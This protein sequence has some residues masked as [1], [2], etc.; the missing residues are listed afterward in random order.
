MIHRKLL[1]AVALAVAAFGA[2]AKSEPLKPYTGTLP[3]ALQY[4]KTAGGLEV[5]KKFPAA[6]GLDG[7][8][9]QDK[10]SGKQLVVYSSK[11]GEVLV[12]G[13]MLDKA[14]K[15]LS[16]TY[17]EEHI[18]APDYTEVM[19]EFM[20]DG[21]SVLV[22][23]P[24]AKAEIMVIFDANCGFCKAMHKL[25]HPAVEAGELRVRYVPV[26]IL[27]ADSDI[28]GAGLLAAKEADDAVTAAVEG[29]AAVSSDKALLDKVKK[30]TALMK[31]HGFGGTP[32]LLYQGK[33]PGKGGKA[34]DTVF[35]SNG[36]PAMSELFARLGISGQVDKLKADPA[37][38]RFLR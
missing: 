26:A 24:K 37:L 14:G 23:S 29:K 36:V 5:F 16:Q 32:V 3:A 30:N 18:P 33:E 12:A 19:A 28:K 10:A 21:A 15:N 31:K 7:W 35:V 22:G 9:V 1:T 11:D 38:A 8:V 20:K 6:G 4:A 27:G 17:A 34:E 2:Q 25:L 13:M